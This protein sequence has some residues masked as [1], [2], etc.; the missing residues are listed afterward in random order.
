MTIH[1]AWRNSEA[2]LKF[3]AARIFKFA[4][5]FLALVP[6]ALAGVFTVLG[7]RGTVLDQP[8]DWLIVLAGAVGYVGANRMLKMWDK[9]SMVEAEAGYTTNRVGFYNVKR[10]RWPSGELIR[11]ARSTENS[12]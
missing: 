2:A 6:L 7:I 12:D 4:L 11:E 9:A 3:P 8:E 5:M 10:V 1:A